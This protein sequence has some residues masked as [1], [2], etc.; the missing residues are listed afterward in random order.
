MRVARFIILF[1]ITSIFSCKRSDS[2]ISNEIRS[3]LMSSYSG[4][5]VSVQDGLVDLS[6]IVKD[7]EDRDSIMNIV[8][9]IKGVDSIFNSIRIT[10]LTADLEKRSS[11]IKKAYKDLIMEIDKTSS[12]DGI[13]KMIS[14]L[15]KLVEQIRVFEDDCVREGV[16]SDLS[17]LKNQSSSEIKK[18]E[19]SKNSLER[20]QVLQNRVFLSGTAHQ[21]RFLSN[22]ILSITFERY[23]DGAFSDYTIRGKYK[24]DGNSQLIV[25]WIG[26][27][28][29]SFLNT[30][31]ECGLQTVRQTYSFD[32]KLF[33]N[34]DM[35]CINANST[36][37]QSFYAGNKCGN[38]NKT[39]RS[40]F[41]F[42]ID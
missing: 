17:D 10:K 2:D 12:I 34:E 36:F 14:R 8:K 33:I 39:N 40:E 19:A 23:Y 25:N 41:K 21:L 1:C 37:S 15:N 32:D 30:W 20:I 13:D 22:N 9:A 5:T 24:F 6:G 4:V 7:V 27:N 31:G 28:D 3:K 35:K 11:S 26:G 42:C 16:M 29:I 38:E 18:L